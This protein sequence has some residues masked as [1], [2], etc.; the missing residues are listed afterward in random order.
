MRPFALRTKSGLKNRGPELKSYRHQAGHSSRRRIC[1]ALNGARRASAHWPDHRNGAEKTEAGGKKF[2]LAGRL[3]DA[4]PRSP[5]V[6]GP[7]TVPP[8]SQCNK[9]L[10]IELT[11]ANLI[12]ALLLFRQLASLPRPSVFFDST[13]RISS[14]RPRE[15]SNTILLRR[16]HSTAP[17]QDQQGQQVS[18]HLR[19]ESGSF[20]PTNCATTCSN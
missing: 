18:V 12:G 16:R 1:V 4:F 15:S 11:V 8:G 5:L 7:R 19:P 20:P 13:E 2:L 10:V 6:K 14:N 9:W 3:A 17:A